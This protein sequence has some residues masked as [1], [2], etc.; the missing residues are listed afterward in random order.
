MREPGAS[1]AS[2][3][4]LPEEEAGTAADV[5][6]KGNLLPEKM[7]SQVLGKKLWRTVPS[8]GAGARGVLLLS[9]ERF[10]FVCFVLGLFVYLIDLSL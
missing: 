8:R 2:M 9:Q 7:D 3:A 10:F 4:T 5:S 1:G 6:E